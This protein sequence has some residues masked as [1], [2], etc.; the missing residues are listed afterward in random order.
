M[1]HLEWN[2]I[3]SDQQYG[4]RE[5]RSCESQLLEFLDE[6]TTHMAFDKVN[7][8]LLLHQLHHYGVRDTL[9]Q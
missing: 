5:N 8:S 3:L 9:N 1:Q 2:T 4:F 6:L 7:H